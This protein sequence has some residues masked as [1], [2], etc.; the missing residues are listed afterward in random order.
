MPVSS[1]AIVAAYEA[2]IRSPRAVRGRRPSSWPPHRATPTAAATSSHSHAPGDSRALV[3][4]SGTP[5][6]ARAAEAMPTHQ[7]AAAQA[8]GEAY[9]NRGIDGVADMRRS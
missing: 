6:Y 7:D 8:P 4:I 2:A 5:E 3:G 9:L 1:S